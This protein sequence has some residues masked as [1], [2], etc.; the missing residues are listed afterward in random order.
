MTVTVKL[1]GRRLR[2]EAEAARVRAEEEAAEAERR[3]LEAEEEA[4]REIQ[5]RARAQAEA[6]DAERRRLEEEAAE[7][8]RR[9]L[10]DEAAA[11]RAAAI[12]EWRK[13]NKGKITI[14]SMKGFDL[15]D[16]DKKGGSGT[17]DPYFRATVLAKKGEA[18]T[19]RGREKNDD[20]EPIFVRTTSLRDDRNPVWDETL[21]LE[22]PY[23]FVNGEMRVEVMDCD[24][25]DD[26]M[27]EDDP[28]GGVDVEVGRGEEE[29]L[30]YSGKFEQMIDGAGT[31]RA[32]R[33]SFKWE[34]SFPPQPEGL[35]DE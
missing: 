21:E 29:R 15:P 3:R 20:G 1:G 31:L 17:S 2:E 26:G 22:V 30:E 34:A 12:G 8:E 7:A 11:R 19:P 32:F 5:R 35:G 24:E 23:D 14:S 6:A 28:L 18:K 16:A 33:I 13:N 10:E 25:I 9:K 4:K 27:N